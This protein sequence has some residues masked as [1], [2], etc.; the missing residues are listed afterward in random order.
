MQ[1]GMT[2]APASTARARGVWFLAS[3][4]PCLALAIVRPWTRQAFAVWDYPLVIPILRQAHGVWD[5]AIAIAA[6]N[7]PDGRANYLS[8]LQFALTFGA[9][10]DNPVGWQ[11]ERALVMLAAALLLVWAARRLGATPLAAAIAATVFAVSVPGTEGWL[12]LAGEP[13]SAVLLLLMV[14]AA[15][16]YRTTP[17][18]R[19]RAV[20][21]ALLAAL[22]MLSKEFHGLC[23]PVIVLF[24][25]CW[26]PEQGFRRPAFGA[27]ERWL[28]LLLFVVLVLEGW[29]VLSALRN[30]VPGSYASQ[31]G[32]SGALSAGASTLFQAM[33]LPA[34][35]SSAG[36]RTVLYP[37]NLIFLM[38][39]VLGLARPASGA[40]RPRGWW[41]WIV[42]LV[43]YPVIGAVTYAV[44]YR[45]SAFYGIPFFLGSAGL[46]AL[47]ATSIERSHRAGRVV[48]AA[49]GGLMIVYTTIVSDR[50]IRQ[51]NATAALALS[52]THTLAARPRLDTLFVVTPRQ[53]GRRWPITGG[54][55]RHYGLAFGGPDSILP[56]MKDASCE[57]VASRLQQPLDRNAVLND[58]NP[59]GRLGAQTI[60]WAADVGYLDWVSLR[61]IADTMRVDLL[62][63]SWASAL[64]RR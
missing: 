17:A 20:V 13:L 53:G 9:A 27:R 51:K 30:A 10:G 19:S 31:F 14:L 63:P 55:L 38:L 44:W 7:R 33:L 41:W 18:W 3:L 24:A 32:R 45:Y 26:D 49:L 54:E 39:L 25:V 8:Y 52:I 16:G 12:F 36:V 6:F 11:I 48:V 4:V 56:V 23:L 35:F 62:V 59:C 57:E 42:G 5:G 46:L 29:S 22:V 21:I 50:T 61:G 60:T 37:A 64:Q 15:A 1:D 40:P 43:S 34:R 2:A 58:Q 28:G 47:A